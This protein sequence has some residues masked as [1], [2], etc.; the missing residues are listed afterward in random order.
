MV[1]SNV[2]APPLDALREA[3]FEARVIRGLALRLTCTL[4]D[5][6]PDRLTALRAAAFFGRG[7][8]AAE[9]AFEAICDG[10]LFEQR[11]SHD[12]LAA[13]GDELRRLRDALAALASDVP[14]VIGEDSIKATDEVS[15]F[16]YEQLGVVMRKL[17][18]LAAPWTDPT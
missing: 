15:A 16:V 4:G 18:K 8:M 7:K 11:A 6:P 12:D 17:T 3:V 14:G 2:T 5:T 10:Q 1:D 9:Q 13:A